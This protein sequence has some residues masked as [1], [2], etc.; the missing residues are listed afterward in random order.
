MQFFGI[1]ARKPNRPR[2]PASGV[3]IQRNP[4]ASTSTI[5][6]LRHLNSLRKAAYRE[7]TPNIDAV[8]LRP[9]QDWGTPTSWKPPARSLQTSTS[10]ESARST[11]QL[12]DGSQ[13]TTDARGSSQKKTV[14]ISTSST[15]LNAARRD[16]T[17]H[18]HIPSPI[19]PLARQADPDCHDVQRPQ[20]RTLPNGR[21]YNFPGELVV[22]LGFRNARI[23]DVRLKG[24]PSFTIS[25]IIQTKKR[26]ADIHLDIGKDDFVT[27]A[28]WVQL[29]TDCPN[30][31]HPAGVV[32]P[33]ADT[34]ANVTE[35]EQYLF[36]HELAARWDYPFQDFDFMLCFYSARCTSWHFLE[37]KGV[38][39]VDA[40]IRVLTRK[41]MRPTKSLPV[42]EA[43]DQQL[44][45]KLRITGASDEAL[46]PG[47][48]NPV[49]NPAKHAEDPFNRRASCDEI[50][51]CHDSEGLG[52]STA[53][54][55]QGNGTPEQRPSRRSDVGQAEVRSQEP[56]S[57]PP[58]LASGQTLVDQFWSRFQ[59][60]YA[61]L[62]ATTPS[63]KSDSNPAKARFYLAYPESARQ[64]L[65]CIKVFLK[66]FTFRINIC[67]WLER[68]SWEAF[69]NIYK[70][71]YI[72]VV[73]VC[74]DSQS[75]DVRLFVEFHDDFREYYKFPGLARLLR[76]SSLSV[77]RLSLSKP[78]SH[79]HEAS[80][81]QRLFPAG[82]VLMLTESVLVS[83][84]MAILNWFYLKQRGDA[85]K[86]VLPPNIRLWLRNRAVVS[87]CKDRE[88]YASSSSSLRTVL[89]MMFPLTPLC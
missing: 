72:G 67:T 43:H 58:K 68:Q 88:K 4:K 41:K 34:T 71:D 56:I 65:E 69:Q 16:S 61:R 10:V 44:P 33:Y 79:C 20:P 87:N 5:R 63:K 57:F 62:T 39:T 49:D 42:D 23:G 27:P 13:N 83:D 53:T 6:S 86:V 70:G 9:P 80:H 81:I 19:T 73:L 64:E 46:D 51:A 85:W 59:I 22:N 30:T 31:F 32:V 55:G 78:L 66:T 74:Q 60:S 77:F 82:Q 2:D 38:F 21:M 52:N 40:K 15:T 54:S 35:M 8:A 18:H 47:I 1:S 37:E 14:K 24:I 25:R 50:R 76:H 26:A 3:L 36:Q 28:Q 75:E 17:S 12:V 29:C 89:V 48:I 11:S 45:E 7:P 84:G